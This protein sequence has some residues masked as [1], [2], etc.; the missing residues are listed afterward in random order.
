LMQEA[1]FCSG[2][3]QLPSAPALFLTAWMVGTSR[4]WSRPRLTRRATDAWQGGA[5]G[6][7]VNGGDH[8]RSSGAVDASTSGRCWVGL[9]GR[10]DCNGLWNDV[11]VGSYHWW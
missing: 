8:M 4:S 6:G 11:R 7:L 2:A 9:G 10:T 3:P 1:C 5:Y